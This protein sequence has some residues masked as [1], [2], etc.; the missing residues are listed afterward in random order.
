MHISVTGISHRTAP[1][2]VRERFALRPEDLGPAL[3]RLR[4]SLGA[5]AI[6]STCNRT[7]VYLACPESRI[8]GPAIIRALAPT[9]DGSGPHGSIFYHH[10]GA[11]AEH[12]VF[13]ARGNL[14]DEQRRQRAQRSRQRRHAGAAAPASRH[15][16]ARRP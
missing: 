3:G 9:W 7:E 1:V 13:P 4:E 16:G 5:V 10:A 6:L 14:A 15:R 2:S 8:N 11:E 12:D